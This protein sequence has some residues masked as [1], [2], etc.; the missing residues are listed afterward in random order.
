MLILMPIITLEPEWD[1]HL[2]TSSIYGGKADENAY[3]LLANSSTE[4]AYSLLADSS[5]VNGTA[6]S[7]GQAVYTS[8]KRGTHFIGNEQVYDPVN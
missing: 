2:I 1:L 8:A 3:S 5:T 7:T 4:N 6:A